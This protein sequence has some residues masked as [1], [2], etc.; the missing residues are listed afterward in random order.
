LLLVM[1]EEGADMKRQPVDRRFSP[2]QAEI[3]S[4][5][6]TGASD[7]EI[8]TSLGISI[9]TV[10]THLQ[11][12]YRDRGLRNRAE[13]VALLMAKAALPAVLSWIS[14]GSLEM[15]SSVSMACP[16]LMPPAIPL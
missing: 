1:V 2:R 5:I 11:R 3:I 15:M 4:L 14:D 16:W 8:A 6:A 10:R 7:K 12:L 9:P 13:A